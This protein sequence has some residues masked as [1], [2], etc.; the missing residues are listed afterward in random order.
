MFI[1][2]L[3]S[4]CIKTDKQIVTIY[5]Y[6]IIMFVIIIKHELVMTLN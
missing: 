4:Q 1:F 6:M 2:T 5:I 3:F